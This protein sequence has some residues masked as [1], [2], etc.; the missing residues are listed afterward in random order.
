MDS[1]YL[2]EAE[3]APLLPGRPNERTLRRWRKQGWVPHLRA[4]GGRIFYT[5]AMLS[6]I[7][8]SMRIEPLCEWPG[9]SEHARVTPDTSGE[10]DSSID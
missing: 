3:A 10:T 8:A 5:I 4:P 9:V 2:S 1:S 7:S 6:E